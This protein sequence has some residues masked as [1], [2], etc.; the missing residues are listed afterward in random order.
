MLNLKPQ[1]LNIDPKRSKCTIKWTNWIKTKELVFFF[2]A[3]LSPERIIS[4]F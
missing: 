2:Q 4:S 3:E 1:F